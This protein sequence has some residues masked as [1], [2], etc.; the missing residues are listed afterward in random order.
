MDG[1]AC[2]VEQLLDRVAQ[3]GQQFH[4][5]RGVDQPRVRERP[6]RPIGGRVLFRQV[7]AEQLFDDRAESDPR[8]AEEPGSQ[9]GVEEATAGRGPPRGGR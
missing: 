8:Q 3:V 9:L 7:D 6:S 4:V 5:E 1:L 2:V